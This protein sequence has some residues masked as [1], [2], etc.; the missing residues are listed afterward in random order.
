MDSITSPIGGVVGSGNAV[1]VQP[2]QAASSVPMA[3]SLMAP[4]QPSSFPNIVPQ[5]QPLPQ[6]SL[7]NVPPIVNGPY[8]PLSVPQVSQHTSAIPQIATPPSSSSLI[9]HSAIPRQPSQVCLL[10]ICISVCQPSVSYLISLDCSPSCCSSY[11]HANTICPAP[12][13]IQVDE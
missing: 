8:A 9:P 4:I 1:P 10:Q 5:H 2:P 7:N 12:K 13:A 11:S 6:H 3:Q